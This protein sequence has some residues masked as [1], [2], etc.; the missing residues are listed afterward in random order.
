MAVWSPFDFN[1][2]TPMNAV[3][4]TLLLKWMEGRDAEA[5]DIEKGKSRS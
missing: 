4:E 2:R 1:E 3:D 5:G